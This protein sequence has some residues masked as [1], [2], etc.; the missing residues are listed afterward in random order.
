L[1]SPEAVAAAVAEATRAIA[2]TPGS[3]ESRAFGTNRTT[4]RDEPFA[5][6]DDVVS[7]LFRKRASSKKTFSKSPGGESVG[8]VGGAAT[9]GKSPG[10]FAPRTFEG[11][12]VASARDV[13]D[14]VDALARDAADSVTPARS[15]APPVPASP[16]RRFLDVFS[17]RRGGSGNVGSPPNAA[18]LSVEEETE[19]SEATDSGASLSRDEG[20]L[21][22]ELTFASPSP[23]RADSATAG[24]TSYS[25]KTVNSVSVSAVTSLPGGSTFVRDA[26]AHLAIEVKKSWF[27]MRDEPGD[28]NESESER[29]PSSRRAE[30]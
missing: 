13:D 15:P 1:T 2:T 17:P 28:L 23:R 3:V 20:E 14:A 12:D 29:S 9:P 11:F 7:P 8:S 21:P 24:L 22:K 30:K 19:D 5:D 25:P 26:E 6:L 18:T 27:G 4:S 10:F 16:F